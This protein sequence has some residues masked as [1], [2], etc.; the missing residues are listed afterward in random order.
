M[1]PYEGKE[2]MA[3]KELCNEYGKKH[4][5]AMRCTKQWFNSGRT[6]IVDTSFASMNLARGLAENGMYMIGNVKSGYSKFPHKWLLSK[7]KERAQRTSCTSTL[8]VGNHVAFSLL[9]LNAST[10]Q[11]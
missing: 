9:K 10:N 3:N 1:E 8:K 6:A 11:F 4:A 2:R 5:K 7:A